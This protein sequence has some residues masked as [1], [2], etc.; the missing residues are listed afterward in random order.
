MHGRRHRIHHAQALSAAL[1]AAA[2][3]G[4]AASADTRKLSADGTIHAV[5]VVYT[6]GKNP[7]SSL[8]HTRQPVGGSPVTTIVP[9]TSDVALDREPAIE[10]DP[11][12]GKLLLVWSRY[13]VNNFN[14]FISR[15]D[16][17]SWSVPTAV[18]KA[19][20]DDVEPQIRIGARYV[21]V[22]WRQVVNGQSSF[23]RQS[24]YSATLAPAYGPEEV[25]T[26][27]LWAVPPEGAATT[28]LP[29]PD[30][31]EEIFAGVSFSLGPEP[32]RCHI[33]GVRDE[34]V[35]IGY[36]ESLLLP[37][38]ARTATAVEAGWLGGRFTVSYVV[39]TRFHY[40]TRVNG[41]WSPTRTLELSGGLTVTDAR[42]IV[43]DL[44]A[45]NGTD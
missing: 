19:A 34:P 28:G 21:H 22:S 42:W 14:V 26:S 40:A 23:H 9:G 44:N 7:G 33:W 18:L 31:S 12:S 25:R 10:I 36:R 5:D 1:V 17:S 20:A 41:V 2:L 15:F 45:R 24:F 39:G 29:D 27:D 30:P 6:G 11:S 43:R 16:G 3:L 35:P 8:K 32:G 37:A 4:S 13:D 38:A